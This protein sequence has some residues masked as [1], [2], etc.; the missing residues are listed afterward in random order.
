[1]PSRAT[2]TILATA[3]A[4]TPSDE[5][6]MAPMQCYTNQPLRKL[7]GLLSPSTIKW[8]EMEKADDLLPDVESALD[9][10]LGGERDY[11]NLVLQLGS[12][13]VDKL[14]AC[15]RVAA[16][17]FPNLR[18]INLN[19]GCPAID[20]GGASTYGASLMKDPSLTARLVES[21]SS[22]RPVY[23]LWRKAQEA[24]GR[25]GFP[26]GA[27]NQ[28]GNLG[29]VNLFCLIDLYYRLTATSANADYSHGKLLMLVYDTR[30][31]GRRVQLARQRRAPHVFP[32]YL[33][34][35]SPQKRS[36]RH[37]PSLPPSPPWTPLLYALHRRKQFILSFL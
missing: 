35:F 26:E 4:S 29:F 9:K 28:S 17:K 31:S 37:L 13:D 8:T 21:I 24:T 36:L 32:K 34:S 12:N 27:Y 18:G 25:V 5:S 22:H 23:S 10:R 19:C 20:A 33:C 15:V 16:R 7:A 11:H 2:A 14:D 30:Y 1:M 3:L 6:H